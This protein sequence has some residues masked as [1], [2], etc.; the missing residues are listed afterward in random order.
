[1]PVNRQEDTIENSNESIEG[2]EDQELTPD[3]ILQ[4]EAVELGLD[5]EG[6]EAK[7][8]VDQ[9]EVNASEAVQ[10]LKND[11]VKIDGVEGNQELEEINQQA[12]QAK[13][14]FID[15][16]EAIKGEGVEDNVENR[17]NFSEMIASCSSFDQL[18]QVILSNNMELQG[19]GN[20][21]GTDSLVNMVERVSSGD[22]DPNLTTSTDGFRDKLLDLNTVDHEAKKQAEKEKMLD[23]FADCSTF[24]ELKQVVQSGIHLEGSSNTWTPDS[25]A[26]SIER[27]ANR[28]LD[29][30]LVTRTGGFRKKLLELVESNNIGKVENQAEG[31]LKIRELDALVEGNETVP[32]GQHLVINKAQDTTITVE[33]G[34]K[35]TIN[36]GMDCKIIKKDNAIVEVKKGMNNDI[37]EE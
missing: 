24:E 14:S 31:N 25:L 12:D 3:Q 30:N 7:D 4:Q 17:N 32:A 37:I 18:K 33:D 34:G 36:K 35:L 1:M 20:N 5:I 16:A 26:D 22:L 2:Q 21:W 10:E 11:V 8:V 23:I 13:S 19:S 9:A 28:T 6:Q 27:V 29:P 15:E